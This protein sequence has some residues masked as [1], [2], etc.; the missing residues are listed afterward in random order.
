MNDKLLFHANAFATEIRATFG[1]GR[2][3]SPNL[4]GGLVQH[5]QLV[6][7]FATGDIKLG[8]CCALRAQLPLAAG[9]FAPMSPTETLSQ[10][11]AKGL[12]PSALPV[13]MLRI[14]AAFFTPHFVTRNVARPIAAI[15]PCCVPLLITA[16]PSF[17]PFPLTSTQLSASTPNLTGLIPTFPLS[18]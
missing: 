5:L 9:G 16:S 3:E 14:V 4:A 13:T 17:N 15:I 10:T 18:S 2:G 7:D 8:S 6:R 11:L 12:R 1:R